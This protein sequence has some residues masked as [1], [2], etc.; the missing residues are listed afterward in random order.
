MAEMM[1]VIED[2]L[3]KDELTARKLKGIL[4]KNFTNFPDVSLSTIKRYHKEIGWVNTQPHYCQL[5]REVNKAKRKDWC[6]M[7]LDKNEQFEDLIFSDEYSV[8]LDHHGRLRFRKEKEP[9]ALKQWPKHP[10]K[11]HIW[12][13]IS[14]R[15]ATRLVMFTGTMNAIRFGKILSTICKDL[16]SRWAPVT[17]GQ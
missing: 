17:N 2:S 11:V 10:V 14:V 3:W 12:G 4:G 8:Q 16:F 15:V 9:R 13:G 6:Q 1:V 7:Q 5:I